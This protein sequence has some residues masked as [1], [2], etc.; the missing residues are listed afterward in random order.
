MSAPTSRAS[1]SAGRSVSRWPTRAGCRRAAVA[2][3]SPTASRRRAS[4]PWPGRS[5]SWTPAAARPE[6]SAR[7]TPELG[8]PLRAAAVPVVVVVADRVLLVVVLVVVLGLVEWASR[9]DLGHDRRLE[10]VGG[11]ELGLGG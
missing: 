5:R 2:R 7:R 9:Y 4:S 1:R 8:Q 11:L 3:S 10:A 6:T